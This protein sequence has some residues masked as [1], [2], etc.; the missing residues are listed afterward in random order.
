MFFLQR[1]VALTWFHLM[2]RGS[3]EK[4]TRSSSVVTCHDRRGNC[5]VMTADG[6]A[7]SLTAARD[8]VWLY[9]CYL[10]RKP[11][12]RRVNHTTPLQI[13]IL[14]QFYSGIVRFLCYS[15]AVLYTSATVQMLKLHTVRWFS[16]HG[17]KSRHSTKITLKV[18]VILNTW[19]TYSANKCYNK[20][21][22]LGPLLSFHTTRNTQCL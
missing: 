2:M 14:I 22:C 9:V 8:L 19:L 20:S 7:S 16:R 4:M 17:W 11:C 6:P 5:V 3:N 18:T 1:K 12:Y 15:M 10:T 13:S 21:S